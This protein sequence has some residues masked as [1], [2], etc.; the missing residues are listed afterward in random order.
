MDRVCGVRAHAYIDL[1]YLIKKSIACARTHGAQ[2]AALHPD[3]T[4]PLPFRR[5]S[6]QRYA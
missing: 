1:Y 4:S 3:S 2:V 5:P 6:L